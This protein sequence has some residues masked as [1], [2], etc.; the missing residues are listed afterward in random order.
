M[1]QEHSYR[2]QVYSYLNFRVLGVLVGISA[3]KLSHLTVLF[4]TQQVMVPGGDF[5]YLAFNWLAIFTQQ[6]EQK[7]L[8]SG[9]IHWS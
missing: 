7:R 9:Y 2:C 1:S 8:K 4:M 5:E 6:T 3:D